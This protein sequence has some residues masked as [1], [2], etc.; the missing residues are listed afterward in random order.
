MKALFHIVFVLLAVSSAVESCRPM[1]RDALLD[2]K[3]ELR[4]KYL[5]IFNSWTG[6]ERCHNWYGVSCDPET[7]RVADI[8]LRGESE[9]PSYLRADQ[10]YRLHN[11]EHLP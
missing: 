2:I 6:A 9:D 5:G 3:A 10:A 1:D 7:R 4:E 8:N 11:G